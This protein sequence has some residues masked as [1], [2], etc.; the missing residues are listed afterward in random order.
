MFRNRSII[1]LVLLVAV[2][3]AGCAY[4]MLAERTQR[5]PYT[6]ARMVLST[7]RG[8]ARDGRD[9]AVPA[10]GRWNRSRSRPVGGELT[11][12]QEEE[13]SRVNWPYASDALGPGVFKRG[14]L[15]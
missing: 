6:L 11:E 14:R 2:F 13:M 4:G 15:A 5:F 9:A 10:T 3:V 7:L 1:R 8:D 12:E